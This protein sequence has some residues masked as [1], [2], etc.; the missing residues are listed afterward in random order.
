MYRYSK[1]ILPRLLTTVLRLT[2]KSI[3]AG[4]YNSEISP[5]EYKALTDASYMYNKLLGST[6]IY[7]VVY[8]YRAY[9]W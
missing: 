5:P 7:I 2:D 1:K 8:V 6:C 4:P 9:I 3:I